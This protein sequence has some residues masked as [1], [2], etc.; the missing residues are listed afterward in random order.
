M[1]RKGDLQELETEV[2]R[3]MPA[4]V[5][6]ALERRDRRE[7]VVRHLV[8]SA[9]SRFVSDIDRRTLEVLTAKIMAGAAAVKAMTEARRAV[10]ELSRVD[11]EL[12]QQDELHDLRHETVRLVEQEK[13]EQLHFRGIRRQRAAARLEGQRVWLERELDTKDSPKPNVTEKWNA[14]LQ[15][16][17]G[18]VTGIADFLAQT[19]Q[20]LAEYREQ[21]LVAVQDD[22]PRRAEK[23]ARIDALVEELSGLRDRMMRDGWPP[24]PK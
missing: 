21:Q 3:R 24:Q 5:M 19:D 18:D 16:F 4:D 22:D 20:W 1:N 7:P 17:R 12:G 15:A 6:H 14:L 2:L 13:Q 9:I 23:L 8:Q 11:Q 10:H